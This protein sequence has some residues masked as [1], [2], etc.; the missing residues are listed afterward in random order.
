MARACEASH[1]FVR[2]PSRHNALR[3]AAHAHALVSPH[4][5]S[6]FL[7][8]TAFPRS[9]GSAEQ[10][11]PSPI[12]PGSPE[13]A[14]LAPIL[15]ASD[16]ALFSSADVGPNVWNLPKTAYVASFDEE[17]PDLKPCRRRV[18]PSSFP[19]S[20]HRAGDGRHDCPQ[21]N[22]GSP[23]CSA[24]ERWFGGGLEKRAWTPPEGFSFL[25]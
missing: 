15:A 6:M 17:T 19:R 22:A 3:S 12:L 21:G 10:V 9:N 20:R 13:A 16:P 18:H 8:H 2:W 25:M 1:P 23:A 11:L 24:H 7:F 5:A 14:K 4:A